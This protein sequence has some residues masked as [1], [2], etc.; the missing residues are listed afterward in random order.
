MTSENVTPSYACLCLDSFLVGVMVFSMIYSL[1]I[2]PLRDG[3]AEY[4]GEA[5]F[6][7]HGLEVAAES[8]N[9]AN[10]PF[11]TGRMKASEHVISCLLFAAKATG[12]VCLII[13]LFE[14][15]RSWEEVITH[16]GAQTRSLDSAECYG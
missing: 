6:G 13:S 5:W 4:I 3:A 14:R 15:G 1:S 8:R 10:S 2:E 11:V 7:C 16:L 9:E 12:V